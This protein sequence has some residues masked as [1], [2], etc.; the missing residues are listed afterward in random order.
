MAWYRRC[1]VDEF[2]D[3]RSLN[4]F[5][6]HG[7]QYARQLAKSGRPAIL[8]MDG[9]AKLIVQDAAAYRNLVRRAGLAESLEILNKRLIESRH[10]QG[11]SLAKW[12]AAMRKKYTIASVA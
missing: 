7:K 12:D 10:S 8:S 6:R 9:E 5:H 11:V 3:I 4:D 2:E 1:I